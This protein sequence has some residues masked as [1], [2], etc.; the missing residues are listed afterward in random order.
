MKKL[1]FLFLLCQMALL[2]YGQNPVIVSQPQAFQKWISVHDSLIL[3]NLPIGVAVGTVGYT[4]TGK[5]V[6]PSQPPIATLTGGSVHELTTSNIT[7]TLNWAYSRN[8]LTAPIVSAVI[9]P[10]SF[11]EFSSSTGASGTQSVTTTANTNTTYSFLVISSDGSSTTATSSV[12]FLPRFY[13]GRSA[14]A[15]PNQTIVL[16]FAGGSNPLTA[17]K[18]QTSLVITASGANYPFFAYPSSEGAI[19]NI[20]DV[21]GFNVTSAF[22]LT[23]VSVTNASS[24]T[25]NYNVYT[26]NA[27]TSSNYTITTN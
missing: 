8:T 12:T 9:N 4:S 17:S 27:A 5:L 10:G 15:T 13:Y 23:V 26:L 14:S 22:N 16:A 2:S 7:T 1:F 24:F 21:N 18:A 19:N 25:Q 20:F 3:V 6:K 11:N